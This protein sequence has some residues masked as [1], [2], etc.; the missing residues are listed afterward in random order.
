MTTYKPSPI[1]IVLFVVAFVASPLL[2]TV[3][4][5]LWLLYWYGLGG[6][7][8][9]HLFLAQLR[10][11]KRRWLIL[12]VWFTLLTSLIYFTTDRTTHFGFPT[13]V[14]TYYGLPT[15]LFGTSYWFDPPVGSAI[16]PLQAVVNWSFYLLLLLLLEWLWQSFR[17]WRKIGA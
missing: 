3:G 8:N 16:N 1:T 4:L 9:N 13:T 17:T 12:A 5:L 14:I 2:T 15:R 7:H 11:I 6:R 10:R